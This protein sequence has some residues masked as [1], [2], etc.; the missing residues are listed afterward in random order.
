MV[1]SE[2]LEIETAGSPGPELVVIGAEDADAFKLAVLKAREDDRG[3]GRVTTVV[4]VRPA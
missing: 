2:R 4:T 1:G 3:A